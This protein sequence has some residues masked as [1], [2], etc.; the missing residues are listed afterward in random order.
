MDD[1]N[2]DEEKKPFDS[3]GVHNDD[4]SQPDPDEHIMLESGH[5]RVWLVKIPKFLM[6]RW[7]KFDAEGV[8]LAKIRIYD[9]PPGTQ[10]RIVVL[11]PSDD[12]GDDDIYELDM[13]NQDVHNQVVVAERAKAPSGTGRARTTIMTG[14]VK[15]ECN[16]RP[17]M[18][19]RY[20]R[21]LAERGA[22]ANER[23]VRVG[24]MDGARAG[25]GGGKML[26][27]GVSSAAGFADLTRAK[28]KPSKGQYERMARMP[29]NQLLDALFALF[30]EREQWPI[31]LLR[32]RTQ[33]PEVYLKEVLSEIASLHRSGEHNGTW[34]LMPS[35]KGDGV[36]YL[37]FALGM[38]QLYAS[39]PS[40][41]DVSM[42][43][44][45]EED[46]DDDDME[47]V[48]E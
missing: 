41:T 20:E 37:S 29:R 44:Y 3:L 46:E 27:S 17:R 8:Q 21:R 11:V 43:E 24:L 31:K 23:S 47:E 9:V 45:D 18:T 6:E 14:K 13:V 35:F 34:E 48:M 42:D 32:E 26:S 33:Q 28:V 22:A 10:P 4:D 30:R 7:S 2:V 40:H 12:G 16:L 36:R 25:R 15:H 1:I 19:G 38:S 5:G 39:Q